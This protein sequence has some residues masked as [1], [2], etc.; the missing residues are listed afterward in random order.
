[1]PDLFVV[2]GSN[3]EPH[4]DHALGAF[5]THRNART[6]IFDYL[7]G[8]P[9][10]THATYFIHRCPLNAWQPS[11]RTVVE[12]ILASRLRAAG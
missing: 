2:I 4:K 9:A 7:S 5:D 6:A 1:M 12:E 3:G 11:S 8:R 10:V